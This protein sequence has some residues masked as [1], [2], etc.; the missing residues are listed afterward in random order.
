MKK[1]SLLLLLCVACQSFEIQVPGNRFIDSESPG[2]LFNGEVLLG[3]SSGVEI[4]VANDING[5]DPLNQVSMSEDSVFGMKGEMGLTDRLGVYLGSFSNSPTMIGLKYQVLGDTAVQAKAGSYS[6]AIIVGSYF[7]STAEDYTG[8]SGISGHAEAD[9]G[10]S[11][12]GLAVG[13]RLNDWNL[14]YLSYFTS[15][16]DIDYVIDR[17]ESGVTTR[18]LDGKGEANGDSILLGWKV[19]P[20]KN[21]FLKTELGYNILEFSQSSPNIQNIE[22]SKESIIGFVIGT[23]WEAK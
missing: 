10:G 12:L 5:S 8:A 7:S 19:Q 22:D 9:F 17:T 14:V 15:E 3:S 6:L 1:Y 20:G 23:N 21:F 16:M 4:V 2:K 13:Y 11:E 18:T